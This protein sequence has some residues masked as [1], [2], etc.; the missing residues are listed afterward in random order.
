MEKIK[1][2]NRSDSVV[3]YRL[4]EKNLQ[5][6]FAPNESKEIS[7]EELQQ[8]IY[9]P[10]GQELLDA[11]F[12]IDNAEVAQEMS[13]WVSNEPEYFYTEADVKNILLKGTVDELLDLLDFGPEGT[14]ELAKSLAISLPCTN[15][16][17]LDALQK[18]F[19][20][21][22]SSM[23]AIAKEEKEASAPKA[24]ERRVNK[25]PEEQPQT[26]ERRTSPN[27]NKYTVINRK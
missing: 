3:G 7:S 4:P 1:V 14:K 9:Q 20:I 26:K 13:P 19:N 18:Y 12:R 23:I 25:E 15:T 2:T 21:N 8:L 17:K 27:A 24:K 10:G 16:L 22:I 5:R 11:Y 6:D